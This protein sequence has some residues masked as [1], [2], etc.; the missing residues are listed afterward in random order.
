MNIKD[1]LT[2]STVLALQG[3]LTEGDLSKDLYSNESN[4]RMELKRRKYE[5]DFL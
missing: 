3:K 2:E 4:E 5:K 1:K